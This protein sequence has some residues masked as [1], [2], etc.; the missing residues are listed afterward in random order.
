MNFLLILLVAVD[1]IYS[2]IFGV[3]A[4]QFGFLEDNA[5]NLQRVD[6]RF[7]RLCIR[8]AESSNAGDARWSASVI[9]ASIF[10][11]LI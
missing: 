4:H 1:S 10:L 3:I 11:K 7:A 9:I 8:A 6:L 2:M 5:L